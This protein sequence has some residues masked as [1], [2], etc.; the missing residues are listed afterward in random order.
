M[1]DDKTL[2]WDLIHMHINV[3]DVTLGQSGADDGSCR[4][5][6]VASFVVQRAG[7]VIGKVAE[8]GF[9]VVVVCEMLWLLFVCC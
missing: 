6:V 2:A 9:V 4:G 8:F 5:G 3:L 1:L 7:C